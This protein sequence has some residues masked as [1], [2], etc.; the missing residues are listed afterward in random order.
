MIR[1]LSAA[2]FAVTVVSIA[3][4]ADLPVTYAVQEKP[5]KKLGVAGTPLTFT[6]Y[7]D[8]ACTQQVYQVVMPIESVGII[9]QV[10]LV[11]PKHA[12]K[13]PVADELRTTLSNVTASG[14][15]YLMVVGTGVTSR[16]SACQAQAA[17]VAPTGLHVVTVGPTLWQSS[18]A[19]LAR[20]AIQ[21]P[22]SVTFR[23]T[24]AS[25]AAVLALSPALP[26]MI[27]GKPT[28]LRAAVLCWD[29]TDPDMVIT[30][31]YVSVTRGSLSALGQAE[32]VGELADETDHNER[33]CLR[34]EL[35]APLD[36]SGGGQV[37]TRLS[38]GWNAS[39]AVLKIAGSTFELDE[40]P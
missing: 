35:D 15:L 8:A 23:S 6:L 5:L 40:A 24:S 16:G 22:D 34:Y 9:S 28:R 3:H 31:A 11:T 33:A 39:A 17:S 30:A 20:V 12:V 32:I 1:L 2:L 13:T 26:A 27:A 36:L 21:Q 29:A 25:D 19:A 7:S 37:S 18:N 10:K 14:N 38:V 4:A